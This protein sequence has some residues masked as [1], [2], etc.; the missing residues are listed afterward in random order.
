LVPLVCGK[1]LFS[2]LVPLPNP[3]GKFPLC[4]LSLGMMAGGE[5]SFFESVNGERQKER[6]NES[7]IRTMIKKKPDCIGKKKHKYS[8]SSW[9][10]WSMG[11]GF[12]KHPLNVVA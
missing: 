2:E 9:K 8:N 10:E 3:G 5:E 1:E 4:S 6:I 7:G 12:L 11:H